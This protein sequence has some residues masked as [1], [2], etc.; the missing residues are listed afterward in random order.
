MVYAKEKW[1]ANSKY[2]KKENVESRILHTGKRKKNDDD[3]DYIKLFIYL[4]R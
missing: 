4:E 2:S 1:S 3:D